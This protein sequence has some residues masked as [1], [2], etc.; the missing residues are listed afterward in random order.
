[1]ATAVLFNGT[2]IP[3]VDILVTAV[4]DTNT[5]RIRL[6]A[7]TVTRG[8]GTGESGIVERIA[9]THGKE[10][11]GF[12][13]PGGEGPVVRVFDLCAVRIGNGHGVPGINN[14]V[15]VAVADTDSKL[16]LLTYTLEPVLGNTQQNDNTANNNNKAEYS[17]A[18]TPNGDSFTT[19]DQN[20]NKR[21]ILVNPSFVQVTTM[22]DEKGV[23]PSYIVTASL[24]SHSS[25]LMLTTWDLHPPSQSSSPSPVIKY[26]D[27]ISAGPVS[28]TSLIRL[29]Y[30][31]HRYVS[32]S[33]RTGLTFS[34]KV[35]LWHVG[36]DG[37]LS[38]VADSGNAAG[39]ATVVRS[40]ANGGSLYTAVKTSEGAL[41]IIRW[42][43]QYTMW[44]FDL[45]RAGDS[46][47]QA[48][49]VEDEAGIVAES[50]SRFTRLVCAVRMA[51]DGPGRGR[52]RVITWIVNQ[53]GLFIR[54]GDTGP[55]GGAENE[56]NRDGVIGEDEDEA[57]YSFVNV[58][59]VSGRVVTSGRT[60]DGR[61]KLVVWSITY[62]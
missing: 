42:I 24:S 8:G 60:E 47:L 31:F 61:L 10:N 52:L 9:D 14:I 32:T 37:R 43:P 15:I 51:I 36:Y 62:S 56:V 3:G 23:L 33:V 6:L 30:P 25:N 16:K 59:F 1:M 38:R 39:P 28:E 40:A 11:A 18:F 29:A 50:G 5:K 53:R 45:F 13:T 57:V 17:H 48:G 4:H 49:P 7:W 22:P 20:I 2:G 19:S 35:V 27:T 46:G 44:T 41:K 54:E 21:S 55:K 26:I 12:E 34:L 58:N